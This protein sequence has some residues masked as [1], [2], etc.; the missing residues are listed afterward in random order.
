MTLSKL[1]TRCAVLLSAPVILLASFIELVATLSTDKV[2][3]IESYEIG[4]SL[5]LSLGYP[6]TWI[7]NIFSNGGGLKDRDNW[8]AIP[9]FNILFLF[10]WIIWA[11]LIV[12]IGRLFQVLWRPF[13]NTTSS[14][15]SV[16]P[17]YV[18][19]ADG[20]RYRLRTS[21]SRMVVADPRSSG[22]WP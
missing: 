22:R 7:V 9:L 1:A 4:D 2:A 20:R 3:K 15:R 13:A 10:Q 19:R 8:W 12:L 18:I 11:Q 17:N 16:W 14:L 5:Y 6:L 21:A